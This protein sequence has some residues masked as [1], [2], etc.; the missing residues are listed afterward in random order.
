MKVSVKQ[1]ALLCICALFIS[2]FGYSGAAWG[3]PRGTVV[4]AQA[5]DPTTLDPHMHFEVHAN[6]VLNNVFDCLMERSYKTGK[7][8]HEPKLAT[9]WEAI[10]D[11]TWVFHLRKGVKFHNGEPFDAEA[12]KFN[13]ER[14]L[15]PAQK[16]KRRTYFTFIDRVEVVDPYTVKIITKYPAGF[17]IANL[18]FAMSI[19]PPKYVKEKGKS[20][21]ASHP[22][23]TG[24]FK[25]VRWLKDQ[26]IVLEANE[27]YWDGPPQI[28]TLIFKPIPEDGTRVAAL[29]AGDVDIAK[30]IPFHL[31]PMI[32]KSKRSRVL[33]TPSGLTVNVFFDT[34]KEGSPMQD[35]RVRQ[36]INY[37]VDNKAIIEKILGGYGKAVG[38]PLN[39][40]HFGYSPKIKPYP[41]DPEKAKALLKEAGYGSGLSLT[42]NSP[43]GRFQKDKEF[44]EAVAGQLAKIGVN[45]KVVVWEWGNYIKKLYSAEGAGPMYT[46]GWGASFDGDAVV[47]PNFQCGVKRSKYC[48]KELDALLAEAR[49]S[50]DVA[51]REKLY[52]KIG[53][54]LREEAP[55]L[56]MHQGYDIYGVRNRVQNWTPTPDESF[57][58]ILHGATLKD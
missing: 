14:V 52:E 53:L 15:D 40:A 33:E 55:C 17:A 19:H 30:N 7:L 45:V 54:F 34:L 58:L 42:L 47:S 31:T 56:W 35:K 36:A 11:T 37:G 4:V 51:K 5:S 20:Y 21:V 43:S 48:N 26:E 57:A 38:S 1:I 2:G 10:N 24:P 39:P 6:V 46:R 3:G 9:S 32:N 25:F 28:R 50:L 44:A 13:I 16:A 18:G 12:V 41:Y 22:V 8:K 29:M 27:D 49:S 23:G